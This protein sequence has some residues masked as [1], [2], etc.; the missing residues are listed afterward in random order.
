MLRSFFAY[1]RLPGGTRHWLGTCA[2]LALALVAAA[3]GASSSSNGSLAAPASKN[4]SGQAVATPGASGGSSGQPTLPNGTSVTA[5]LIR[6]LTVGLQ[7]NKPL[8]AERQI[9]Q[10]VFSMDP[11]AQAA[12]EQ[13]NEQSDGSYAVTLTFAVSSPK[14]ETVKTYLGS[15]ATTYPSFKAKL[16]SE[17]E[18]VQN[19][20]TEYVDLQSRLKN[21]R[22]E[23]QRLL[24]L[25]SQAQNLSDT[26]TIQDKLTDVEGQIEQIEGQINE[27]SSQTSYS[28]VTVKLSSNSAPPAPPP[29]AAPKPWNPGQI[30]SDAASTMVA[31]LQVVVDI[32]IWIAVF[33]VFWLPAAVVLYLRRRLKRRAVKPGAVD[34][35]TP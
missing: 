35:G 23:Q 33:A 25:M 13:I 2:L 20:T 11:Q 34:L 10:D 22:T 30:F 6:S 15:F 1:F 32:L 19:V 31:I 27:L 14:Y 17:N 18:T 8:D 5:Y 7:V 12:G 28:T 16:T 26:L 24:Q 9:S 29:P 21:L 3:C 4:T